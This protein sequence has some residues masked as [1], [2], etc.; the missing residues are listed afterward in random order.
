MGIGNESLNEKAILITRA[1]N[2]AN[3]INK[4]EHDKKSPKTLKIAVFKLYQQELIQ[5]RKDLEKYEA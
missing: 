4:L 3:N 5:I 1:M 2:I